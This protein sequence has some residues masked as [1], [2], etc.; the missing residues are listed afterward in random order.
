MNLSSV[1]FTQDQISVNLQTNILSERILCAVRVQEGGERV[2]N[3]R[4]GTTKIILGKKS[5]ACLACEV[6]ENDKLL[7]HKR[8]RLGLSVSSVTDNIY[9]HFSIFKKN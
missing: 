3:W 6:G 9:L 2:K 1:Q 8:Q 4:R 5:L 7:D